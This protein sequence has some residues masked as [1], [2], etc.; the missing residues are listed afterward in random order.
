MPGKNGTIRLF[1]LFGITVFLHWSWFLVA[2]YQIE[3][4]G[5]YSSVAWNIAE[6][7]ALFAIVT[8]H[9]FGHALACRQVGGRAFQIVLW[10]L[11]G[12]AYVDPPP[13]PG[14]TLWSIAAG[15]LVN[16]ALMPLLGLLLLGSSIASAGSSPDFQVFVR[17]LNIINL[18]LFIF[19]VLPIYP[20][21]GGKMLR[22]LLWYVVGRARSLMGAVIV[23]FVGVA[24]LGALAF[25][26]QSTW[27]AVLTVFAGLQCM[28]G[29]KQAQGLQ[30]LANAP[31]R[32]TFVCP[33]CK[34]HPIRGA[35]WLCPSCRKSFD[36]FETQAACPNCNNRFSKTMCLDCGISSSF[37]DWTPATPVF[38]EHSG[39]QADRPAPSAPSIAPVVLAV[40]AWAAAVVLIVISLLFFTVSSSLSSR[41]PQYGSKLDLL[42][43]SE[44]MAIPGEQ[45]LVLQR[46][47]RYDAY[48][49]TAAATA[50]RL[51]RINIT[52]A[53]AGSG[54][55]VTV[56]PSL[57]SKPFE[58]DERV[59]WAA[60][61]FTVPQSGRYVVHASGLNGLADARIKIGPSAALVQGSTATV[62]RGL[63]I[64]AAM[65]GLALA[66]GGVFLFR[67]YRRRR[68]EFDSVLKG[69]T[70]E[71][72]S[73]R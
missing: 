35:F 56:R 57:N 23:G 1:E 51:D 58:S 73:V 15:P 13:R 17:E 54:S 5:R 21:D 18:G 16:V 22:A 47:E 71:T 67:F 50:P 72:T 24:G 7:V 49:E 20:L 69:L 34:S 65:I 59:L 6:Y 27:L 37:V 64:G 63:A 60:I 26:V 52:I 19:N 4:R 40:T 12:V 25:G 43:Q 66:L 8:M 28:N 29:W 55:P 31:R 53:N 30:R 3:R 61:T 2:V 36:T 39:L 48:V 45:T 33:S 10:P 14:A 70:V 44:G 62:G 11:G 32:E 38:N 68:R 46:G 42:W 9:E 41:Q